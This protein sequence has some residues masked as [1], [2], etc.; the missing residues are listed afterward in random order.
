VNELDKLRVR[1]RIRK[2]RFAQGETTQQELATAVGCSRQTIVLLEQ[3]CYSPSL[4]L[5]FLIARHFDLTVD[6]VFEFIDD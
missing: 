1:N 4:T 5:A 3:G 6:A 2:L